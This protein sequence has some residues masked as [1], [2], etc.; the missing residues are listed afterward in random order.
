MHILRKLPISAT[1][2]MLR[3]QFLND[4]N[5][6]SVLTC[7]DVFFRLKNYNVDHVRTNCNTL[8]H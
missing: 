8:K 3:T 5:A 7:R 1:S 6:S 4:I 2:R